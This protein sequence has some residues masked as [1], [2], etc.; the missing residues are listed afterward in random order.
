MENTGKYTINSCGIYDC[1]ENWSWNNK[2]S[3]D[4]N[5]WAVFRGEGALSLY[6]TTYSA[7]IGSC[8]LIPPRTPLFGTHNPNNRLLVYSVHFSS[9]II[10]LDIDVRRIPNTSFFKE[11]FNRVIRFYNMDQ[12]D[13]ANSCLSVL[14]NEFFSSVNVSGGTKKP[15]NV[16][17]QRCVAEICD[18]I[19]NYPE[20]EHRLSEL[21]TE[22]G[23]SATHL[24]KIFH[25]VIGVT[26]SN[27]LLNARI[28]Y[29]RLLLL[30]SEMSISEI[31]E[32]LGYYDTAHFINQFKKSVGCTPS[33][34]R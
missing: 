26:F 5:L 25:K 32:K 14:L 4:Y 30:S 17:H 34:Y 27:Y 9:D 20:K 29:A 15:E 33:A 1:D 7:M 31:A 19:N 6:D 12:I 10:P 16:A 18:R 24:G 13:L 28:N 8:F 11:L 2:C 21:A 23:Y 22:Y 3:R